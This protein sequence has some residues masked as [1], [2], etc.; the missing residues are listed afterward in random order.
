MLRMFATRHP[1]PMTA[2]MKMRV[3]TWTL[4]FGLNLPYTWLVLAFEHHTRQANR[5]PKSCSWKLQSGPRL[6]IWKAHTRYHL[7]KPFLKPRCNLDPLFILH[8]SGNPPSN[9]RSQDGALIAMSK[10]AK[11]SPSDWISTNTDLSTAQLEDT[12]SDGSK[13]LKCWCLLVMFVLLHK[14][15]LSWI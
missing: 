9:D 10:T 1:F 13:R 5:P 11:N 12:A 4:Y 8:V 6:P 2:L 7:R 14:P 3:V 15:H